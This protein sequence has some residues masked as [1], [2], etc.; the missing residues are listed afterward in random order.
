MNLK[1]IRKEVIYHLTIDDMEVH[2]YDEN[3]WTYTIYYD[4]HSEEM[5][6]DDPLRSELEKLFQEHKDLI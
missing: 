6:I 3:H 1:N 2:R 5:N 4:I